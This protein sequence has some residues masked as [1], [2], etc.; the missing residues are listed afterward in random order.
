MERS[1]LRLDGKKVNAKKDGF[2]MTCDF[3]GSFLHLW[4]DCRDRQEHRETRK[5]RTYANT[6]EFDE[7]GY[8]QEEDEANVHHD[9]EETPESEAFIAHH[10]SD[11]GLIRSSN[12]P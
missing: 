5:F 12:I 2:I 7:D 4:K 10:L 3:C 11:L 9:D 1:N 8:E 6:E